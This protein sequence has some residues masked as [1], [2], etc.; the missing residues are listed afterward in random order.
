[1]LNFENSLLEFDLS[2]GNTVK[3]I[4]KKS[5][6]FDTLLPYSDNEIH[7]DSAPSWDLDATDNRERRGLATLCLDPV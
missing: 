2:C 3:K 1:M 5:W 4:F 7:W 6:Q